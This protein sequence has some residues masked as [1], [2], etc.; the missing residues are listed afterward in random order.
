MSAGVIIPGVSSSV[1][2]MLLNTYNI[3]LEAIANINF[4]ILIPMGI[5]L[6]IGCIIFLKLIDFLFKYYKLYT[7]YAII[8]FTIGAVFVIFPG[9][10]S[11]IYGVFSIFLFFSSFIMAFFL[12]KI[13]K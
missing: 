4:L 3:Y 9:F 8:G 5:G 11:S 2:L 13:N 1:I 12:G 6:L 7:Y 10:E